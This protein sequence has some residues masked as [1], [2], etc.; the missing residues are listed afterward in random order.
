MSSYLIKET[1][2]S[3]LHRLRLLL[4]LLHQVQIHVDWLTVK[5]PPLPPTLLLE[6]SP[7]EQKNKLE[8]AQ[9]KKNT[10]N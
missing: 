3:Q 2:T 1:V 4:L 8:M 5:P 10:R 6:S 7:S 9:W